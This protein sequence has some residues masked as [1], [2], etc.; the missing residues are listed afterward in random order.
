MYC[1]E[2]FCINLTDCKADHEYKLHVDAK[3]KSSFSIKITRYLKNL[4]TLIFISVDQTKQSNILRVKLPT[5]DDYTNQMYQPQ[6]PYIV[7]K[8]E[9]MSNYVPRKLVEP[10]SDDENE[11]NLKIFKTFVDS[12][13]C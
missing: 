7:M 11:G 12:A 3:L 5:P 8:K 2:G 13:F 1:H 10:L 6:R 9:P 4:F